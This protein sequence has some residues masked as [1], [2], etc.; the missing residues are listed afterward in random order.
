MRDSQ[1]FAMP[2]TTMRDSQAFLLLLLALAAFLWA[3]LAP[4]QAIFPHA[5]D[6]EL[7]APAPT[8]SG[9][10]PASSRKHSDASS[11]FVPE[12][13]HHL[14]DGRARGPSLWNPHVELGRP[15]AQVSA[16]SPAFWPTRV[17][18]WLSSDAFRVYTLLAALAIAGSSVF[19]MLLLRAEGVHPAA[20]LAGAL[21]IGLGVF[22]TY[23]ATYALFVFGIAW[24]FAW[25]WLNRRL[26]DQRDPVAALG[27]VIV[28][29]ALLLSGYPQQIV[30]HAI[31]VVVY[32][33]QAAAL[34][35]GGLR[36]HG[37]S[38]AW[39]AAASTLG[40][41]AAAP[42]Y[43][44]VALDAARSSRLEA[45]V[46]FFQSVLPRV[47]GVGDAI[48]QAAQLLDA[49]L[50]GDP[51]DPMR[52]PRF[53]GLSLTPLVVL[54]LVASF[55]ARGWRRSGP[56]LL[57]V[58]IA[59]AATYSS[60]VHAVGVRVGLLGVSRF[61]PLA[62]ALVPIAILAARGYDA[63]L[64]EPRP[65]LRLAGGFAAGILLLVFATRAFGS[66]VPTAPGVAIT[67]G[68]GALAT[69][70]ALRPSDRLL[71]AIAVASVFVH[72]RPHLLVRPIDGIRTD[73]ELVT[74]LRRA[75]EDGSRFAWVDR[76]VIPANQE[77]LLGLHSVHSYNSLSSR[78]YQRWTRRVSA[79]GATTQG[80]TFQV[81]HGTRHL[82]A[83]ALQRAGIGVLVA[84]R[85]LPS[86]LARP[87]ARVGRLWI[88]RTVRTPVIGGH[89]R[90]WDPT[91][92][93]GTRPTRDALEDS[94]PIEVV[95]D[96]ADRAQVVFPSS[97]APSLVW[98]GWQ[99]H[100]RWVARTDGRRLET[101]AVDDLFLG[102]L[103][104][105][106]VGGMELR[107]EPHA[108]WAWVP[109]VVLLVAV[110]ICLV[111]RRRRAHASGSP[112]QAIGRAGSARASAA[113]APAARIATGA[114]ESL[115]RRGVA[116]SMW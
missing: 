85:R 46:A 64:R 68:F 32:T 38:L 51:Y 6:R 77:A 42:V 84:P 19:S 22:T 8:T 115:A 86:T 81:V 70:L 9:P 67:L 54:G 97:D 35:P 95:S 39:I 106:G 78:A 31:F 33:L 4:G 24:T 89:V 58:A 114:L 45:P 63:L 104:P 37:R 109:Q 69:A 90:G 23:W 108:R 10:G 36:R 94:G 5:N 103:V 113:R 92:A 59:L 48:V 12:L 26:L 112:G 11:Q 3:A 79:S 57:F 72:A 105:A 47:D 34:A 27:V 41:L 1:A 25:L 65:R 100:P 40:G 60:P 71:V 21:G 87:A 13:Q 80:R 93:G 16:I 56:L 18:G 76:F 110:P 116:R 55:S 49:S 20:A 61:V 75:T 44:D 107:F 91:G 62:G 50:F 101:L 73:S 66:S 43:L 52:S 88:H 53:D 29:Q 14:R 30:W 28:V 99:F 15:T 98:L 2:E 7:G 82:S 96:H 83:P 17:L 111:A 74:A 102:V